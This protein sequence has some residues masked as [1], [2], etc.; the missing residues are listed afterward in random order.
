[1]GS[2]LLSKYIDL[3]KLVPNSIQESVEFKRG[4]DPKRAMD[5][6]IKPFDW[7]ELTAAWWDSFLPDMGGNDYEPGAYNITDLISPIIEDGDVHEVETQ[8]QYPMKIKISGLIDG[9]V[10]GIERTYS[11]SLVDLVAEK[12]PGDK[13]RLYGTYIRETGGGKYWDEGDNFERADGEKSP[14]REIDWEINDVVDLMD[15]LGDLG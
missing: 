5:I 10:D 9:G 7:D 1:L 11:E 13:I 2:Y 14:P 12:L 3:M 4:A 15:N 6:G 8:R